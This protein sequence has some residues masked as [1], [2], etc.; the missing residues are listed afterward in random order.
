MVRW[1]GVSVVAMLGVASLGFAG[2]WAYHIYTGDP[3]V[4]LQFHR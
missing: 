4:G 3:K 1:Y 2:L